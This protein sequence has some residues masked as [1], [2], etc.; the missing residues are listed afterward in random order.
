MSSAKCVTTKCGAGS[1]V[2]EGHKYTLNR[3]RNAGQS[4]K[5]ECPGRITQDDQDRVISSNRRHSYVADETKV[6]ADKIIETFKIR[7]ILVIYSTILHLHR[8]PSP[9]Q[10]EV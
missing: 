8:T 7:F 2:H 9:V 6:E 10:D 3:H 5:R 4:F 1:Q